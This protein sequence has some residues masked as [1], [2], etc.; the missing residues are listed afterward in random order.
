MTAIMGPSGA[1]KTTLMNTLT[2]K[3]VGYGVQ[4][5]TVLVNGAA[6]ELQRYKPIMGFVPQA[7][8]LAPARHKQAN[9]FSRTAPGERHR[10]QVS[11]T[12]FDSSVKP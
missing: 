8:R 11:I 10:K 5:G 2:G 1:G 12:A 3:A 7:R 9:S 4:T 6:E